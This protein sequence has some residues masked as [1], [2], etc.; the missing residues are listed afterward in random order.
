M[1]HC[2]LPSVASAANTPTRRFS[3]FKPRF[4]SF[5]SERKKLCLTLAADHT[6][7][8]SAMD[9]GSTWRMSPRLSMSRCTDATE[10]GPFGAQQARHRLELLVSKEFRLI[11]C[12]H[13]FLPL[14]VRTGTPSPA[15]RRRLI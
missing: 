7:S 3:S 10:F 11:F 14:F 4:P 6:A 12:V 9:S 5:S 8:S 1:Y 15:H 13:P 2:R